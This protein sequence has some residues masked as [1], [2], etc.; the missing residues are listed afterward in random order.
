MSPGSKRHLSFSEPFLQ[1]ITVL[2]LLLG[3]EFLVMGQ[4]RLM[5][6]QEYAFLPPPEIEL[7]P[8]DARMVKLFTL[9]FNTMTADC[10]FLSMLQDQM[11]PKTRAQ[12]RPAFWY[13][14]DLATDL[15]PPFFEAYYVGALLTSIA[16]KDPQGAS[17]IV[18]KA[19]TF[20]N[21]ELL[22]EATDSTDPL[23]SFKA[24][25]YKEYWIR[26]WFLYV[27]QGYLCLFELH[28]LP[29]AALAFK[30]AS[31]F[32]GSP[33]YLKSLA[34]KFTTL[35][36]VYQIAFRV[37]NFMIDRAPNP[38]AK[39]D[40]LKQKQDLFIAQYVVSAQ[41]EFQTW[42]LKNLRF[43]PKQPTTPEQYQQYFKE[44]LH[45]TRTP[46]K[47]PWGGYLSINDQGMLLTSTPHEDTLGI[48]KLKFEEKG[49]Q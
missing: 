4:L 7:E 15:D 46:I 20:I 25:A 42:L 49:T 37:L 12:K 1:F 45:Q 5:N 14:I 6:D 33:E 17:Q 24:S 11:L 18:N 31:L 40:L 44:Y 32:P 26:G 10:L 28:S 16:R 23:D 19:S 21:T 29:D 36:G 41:K 22:P 27:I 35:D 47:D 39:D 34:D 2:L 9:G 3:S 30:K 43:D 38:S 48:E 13:A 8:M